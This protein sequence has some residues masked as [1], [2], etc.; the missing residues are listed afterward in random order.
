MGVAN[1]GALAFNSIFGPRLRD[2][3]E[4]RLCISQNG[5]EQKCQC[6]TV[7]ASS[8]R[9]WIRTPCWFERPCLH[10][11]E[12][13][14]EQGG[15]GSGST[16]GELVIVARHIRHTRSPRRLWQSGEGETALIGC[17]RRA[18][19]LY[20]GSAQRLACISLVGCAYHHPQAEDNHTQKGTTK[21][22]LGR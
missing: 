17:C 8:S 1:A 13:E 7:L 19:E 2:Q 21:A 6:P 15:R 12:E 9:A 5:C 14:E 20:L 22:P 10:Q 3:F 16:E 4:E 11:E 18:W